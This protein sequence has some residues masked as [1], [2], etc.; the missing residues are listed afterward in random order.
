MMKKQKKQKRIIGIDESLTKV[1]NKE[2][3]VCYH[4][5]KLLRK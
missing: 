1:I 2:K 5:M 3:D 4:Y